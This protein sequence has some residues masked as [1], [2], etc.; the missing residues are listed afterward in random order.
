MFAGSANGYVYALDATTGHL[1]WKQQVGTF[2]QEA[3]GAI[4]GAGAIDGPG[5]VFLVSGARLPRLRRA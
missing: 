1:V 2:N 5:V 4:T 3:G